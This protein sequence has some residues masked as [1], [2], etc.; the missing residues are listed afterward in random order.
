MAAGFMGIRKKIF[1]VIFIIVALFLFFYWQNNDIVTTSVVYSDTGV[2]AAFDGFRILQVSDLHNKEFGK[3]QAGLAKLT[4]KLQPDIIVITGDL[5]DSQ[6]PDVRISMDYVKQA[7]NIAPVYFITGNHEKRSDKYPELGRQL[8]E[9]GV[10]M[11]DDR[12]VLLKKDEE[13]IVLLGV[14]DPYFLPE[15]SGRDQI[16]EDTIH[17]ISKEV[18]GTFKILLSHRPELI[19]LYASQDIDLV[20]SGHAHGGQFRIPFIGG[21]YAPNQGFFPKYTNGVIVNKNTSMVVSRGLGNSVIPV[22]IFNRPE[23]VTVTLKHEGETD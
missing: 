12:A 1:I 19:E 3:N 22:R 2:P 4:K 18:T 11:L 14:G 16:M 23:L 8:R 15:D 13:I 6:R 10:I 9:A 5:I 17:T 21:L 7:V 20:F